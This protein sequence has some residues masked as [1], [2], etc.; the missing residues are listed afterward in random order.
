MLAIHRL[1]SVPLNRRDD[2]WLLDCLQEAIEIEFSTI[3]PYLYARWSL[4]DLTPE[5][6]A[7]N[8]AT[9]D[10]LIA[11]VEQEMLHMGTA[12]NVLAGFGGHPQF[13]NN[14]ARPDLVPVYPGMLKA[15]VHAG[16]KVHLQP[17]SKD[18]LLKGF[19][20]IEEPDKIPDFAGGPDFK[21]TGEK[22][23][24]EFYGEILD[25]LKTKDP[26]A[27]LDKG[28]QVDLNFGG[29]A[30]ATVQDA[31]DGI[32][33]I[34]DQ[35][36]GHAGNPYENN[37]LAH[38]YRFGQLYYGKTLTKNAP[39]TYTDQPD[40]V[41]SARHNV[42]TDPNPALSVV[43]DQNYSKMLKELQDAWDAGANGDL[44]TAIF[45]YMDNMRAEAVKLMKQQTGP[46][47]TY[48]PPAPVA[49]SP[50]GAFH[51][52]AVN[53]NV[54]L[55]D[56]APPPPTYT[57]IKG[58]LDRA[59]NNANFGAH[60]AFWRA[61]DRDGFVAKRVFG[62]QLLVVG[63]PSNSNIIKALRG[64]AP[65]GSDTGTVGASTRRMPAG[66]PAMPEADIALI[67]DWIRQGCPPDP[68]ALALA[69]AQLSFTTGAHFTPD[70]HNA[71]WR[72]F[73]NW[74]M[75][76]A[77]PDVQEA[78]GAVLDLFTAWAAFAKD[79]AREPAFQA[80]IASDA[81]VSALRLL[82]T[83]QR[84]TVESHY[85]T[86]APLLAL[87]DSYQRFGAGTLPVDPLR[88]V[89]PHHQMNGA[90]M[91]FVWGAFVEAA[92]R[93]QIEPQFWLFLL[94]AILCG[95]LSDGL[96]RGRFHVERFAPGQT[97]AIFHYVQTIS[98]AHLLP[99]IRRRY[100]QS[101]L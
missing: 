97:D 81:T 58:A 71:Y 50:M 35:G 59:V 75:F 70:Q 60:G 8:Q 11:I 65:F 67:E 14:S 68:P 28:K 16:L 36:E 80:A 19:M 54:Q 95:L 74:S 98:D 4:E 5:E 22:T 78:V 44:T 25:Y 56:P 88:P 18:L 2:A 39:F 84:L 62:K 66:L 40:L 31:I 30:F 87:L 6:I 32:N 23:I 52:M 48:I 10:T 92:V 91:W 34:V 72:D 55:A 73:D 42:P 27:K 29:A 17:I 77:A 45:T 85:G 41:F 82:S 9:S 53:A 24:G 51:A 43:F 100:A 38:F 101:G 79:P 12:A 96:E 49:P 46:S 26:M 47:F 99:E 64:I 76:N 33:L 94:R 86:P 90:A 83:K 63:D 15:G 61:L 57:Q 20:V 69:A 13:V 93:R 3:P 37:E 7:A 21:P 1:M 89:D